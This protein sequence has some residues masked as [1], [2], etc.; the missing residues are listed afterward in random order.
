MADPQAGVSPARVETT[1]KVGR[2][3]L[4]L[5]SLAF[6]RELGL[7]GLVVLEVAIVSAL[8][9]DTFPTVDNFTA[10]LRNMAGDGIM[11]V[12]MMLLLIGGVFDLSIG[13]MFSLTG[14]LVGWFLTQGGLSVPLAILCALA[15]A[16]LGGFLNGFVVAKVGVNALIT[17][18]GTLGIFKGI[19]ILI[20]GPGISFLPDSFS[21]LGQA[22]FARIQSPV[23]LMLGIG[24]LFH[25]LLSH[26]RYFRQYY[27]I[28]GN[29]RAAI[30]SG[31][32][33]ARM[34]ILAFTLM[35]LLAGLAGIAFASRVAS[36]VSIAGDG[37]ELR[38]ITAVIL[39]GASLA[40][41]RGT[42]WGALLG[43]F[44]IALLGNVLIIA[45]VGS[46]YQSIVVGLVLVGAVAIDSILNRERKPW[47]VFTQGWKRSEAPLET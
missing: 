4:P 15:L 3:R 22:E 29:E 38:V 18:L 16:A 45:N 35:G 7:L 27:Y 33:V 32:K 41:G 26:T 24:I 36:S 42:V 46:E 19:A 17:T 25:Y 40:G 12:G 31:I 8:Y 43:V 23:W 1:E 20:A 13:A 2:P 14:V 11:A 10:I 44:F 9:P 28:G 5:R 47:A 34:Q 21:R 30:L 39:G 6:S 37:A